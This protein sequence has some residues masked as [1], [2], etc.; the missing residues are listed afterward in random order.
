MKMGG[1]QKLNWI[2]KNHDLPKVLNHLFSFEINNNEIEEFQKAFVLL[3]KEAKKKLDKFPPFF[4]KNLKNVLSIPELRKQSPSQPLKLGKIIYLPIKEND[5]FYV[6]GDIHGDINTLRTFLEKI[7]FV[8]N[9]NE[10]IKIILLGDYIDRGLHG[11]NI[12]LVILFLKKHFHK[13]V[14]LLQGNHEV[15]KD[16]KEKLTSTATGDNLFLE[17]W[18]NHFHYE[19][20]KE[21]KN[22]FDALPAMLILSNGIILVHGGIPRP[23]EENN[24]LNYNYLKSLN[25][26]NDNSTLLEMLWSRPEEKEDVIITYG[27]HDFSFAKKQY[28]AFINRIKGKLMIRAHDPFL[29]GYQAFFNGKL[30]SIFSTGGEGNQTAYSPYTNINPVYLQIL[31]EDINIYPIFPFKKIKLK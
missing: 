24:E 17:F 25:N 30:L 13:Q 3:I 9:R 15:W 12:L 27:S 20:L 26:L 21:I 11:L 14:F 29:P 18:Q 28:E 1:H 10:N 4:K 16:E 7:H 19:T 5:C 8:R 31:P 6:L 23:R 22:F 2:L